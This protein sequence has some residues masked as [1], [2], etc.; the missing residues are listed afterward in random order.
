LNGTRRMLVMVIVGLLL[1]A[2]IIGVVT[3][4]EDQNI[5][6][7][8]PASTT[9]ETKT[10][11]SVIS[12]TVSSTVTSALPTGRLAIQMADPG[13][14][15]IGTSHVYISYSDIEAHTSNSVNPSLWFTIASEGKLDLTGLSNY[16]ITIGGATVTAGSYDAIR[17]TITNSSFTYF[18]KNYTLSFPQS[19][20]EQ[21]IQ[22]GGIRLNSG[23]SAGIVIDFH[24]MIVQS[25]NGSS[26]NFALLPTVTAFPI[27]STIWNES[28]LQRGAN[29]QVSKLQL[30]GISQSTYSKLA[31]YEVLFSK[32]FLLLY[33]VNRGTSNVT[34]S[35][36]SMLG[37]P[38]FTAG[39]STT[40]QTENQTTVTVTV[41]VTK[42]ATSSPSY[43][44]S[45]MA[46]H[47]TGTEA[48]PTS[49]L[50]TLATFVVL[51]N[52]E[53][54]QPNDLQISS[55]QNDIGVTVPPGGNITLYCVPVGGI[56]TMNSIVPPYSPLSII[57][58]QVY[59][60]VVADPY[61]NSI[62]LNAT[63]F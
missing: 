27:P 55:L 51:K 4:L 23:S 3:A 21:S 62:S 42:N 35:S 46:S 31:V 58:G 16:S 33:L 9:I 54:I 44:V 34:I 2:T 26:T 49:T 1:A 7:P 6:P 41:T 50:Q 17:F 36:V 61:G 52:G 13:T 43:S 56:S 20:I 15:P 60:I 32:S 63:A 40:T 19:Q 39:N 48:M 18:G 53:V 24:P 25:N 14:L 22:N 47:V 59:T 28:L 37:N 30:P 57:T 11:V 38:Y 10:A 12:S 8:P 29:I 5:V 45:P